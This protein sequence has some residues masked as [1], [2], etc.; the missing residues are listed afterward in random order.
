MLTPN[1]PHKETQGKAN[2]SERIEMLKLAFQ[3]M[4]NVRISDLEQSLPNPSYTLQTLQ[5]LTKSYPDNIFFLC[6]GEDSIANFDAWYCYDKILEYC[7]LIAVKRP[8]FDASGADSSVLEKTIFIDH[9]P[10]DISSTKIRNSDNKQDVSVPAEVAEYIK[11]NNLY[12][13]GSI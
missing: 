13:T 11:K 5:H 4:P 3:D 8:G 9:K 1:P 12:L 10:L 2:Y 7:N 6:L